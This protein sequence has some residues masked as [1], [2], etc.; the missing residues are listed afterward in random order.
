MKDRIYLNVKKLT[1]K[2]I[3]KLSEK[4]KLIVLFDL[5]NSTG[6]TGFSHEKMSDIIESILLYFPIGEIYATIS[7]SEEID[8]I[9]G[10]RLLDSIYHFIGDNFRLYGMEFF[11]ELNGKKFSELPRHIKN[12]ILETELTI[13]S[14]QTTEDKAI[15]ESF[16]RRIKEI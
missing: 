2:Q 13:H 7:P 12:R 4:D 10:R 3:G 15:I 8:V 9:G 6:Y 16:R 11:P 14:I 1:I 5:Y